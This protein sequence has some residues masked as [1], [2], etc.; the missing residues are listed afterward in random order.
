[1]LLLGLIA[2]D[3]GINSARLSFARLSLV[4]L[5]FEEGDISRLWS[6]CTGGVSYTDGVTYSTNVLPAEPCAAL[7]FVRSENE[8]SVKYGQRKAST[9]ANKLQVCSL[10]FSLSI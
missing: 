2:L 10:M 7:L 6:G 8:A 9:S 5:L 4:G 1:M 3:S